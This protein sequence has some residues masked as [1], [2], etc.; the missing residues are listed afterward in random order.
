[1]NFNSIIGQDIITVSLKNAK[2]NTIA[3]GYILS[4]P[5][6]WKEAHGLYFAMA[7]NC[8]SRIEDNPRGFC[9][10]CIRTENGS[11]PNV[12][13]VK[14]TGTTIKIKQIRDI[15]NEVAKNHLRAVIRW[16]FWRMLRK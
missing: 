5:R 11:H 8:S 7:L 2:N 10:S 14:P 16:L 6:G 9:S 12:E 1:M 4:G 13:I 3:N 15:I